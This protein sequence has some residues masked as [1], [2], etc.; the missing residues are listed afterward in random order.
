[1]MIVVQKLSRSS[2]K[3]NKIN[4]FL[5]SDILRLRY[6]LFGTSLPEPDKSGLFIRTF[7][8]IRYLWK[9]FHT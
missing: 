4:F 6:F 3:R 5:F 1:M 8:Q 9:R 7:Q 2:G